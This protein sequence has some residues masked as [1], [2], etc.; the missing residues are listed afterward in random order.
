MSWIRRAE[1]VK[2]NT[3]DLNF[4]VSLRDAD[5]TIAVTQDSSRKLGARLTFS[6][7]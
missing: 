3:N 6:Y 2:T 5:A 1:Q 4:L 7:I